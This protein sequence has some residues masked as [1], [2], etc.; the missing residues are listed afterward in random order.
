MGTPSGALAYQ[1]GRFG[2]DE[3]KSGY[4]ASK[5]GRR[6]Y[7]CDQTSP[8]ATYACQTSFVATTPSLIIYKATS[9]KRH[10]VTRI[11]ASQATTAAGGNITAHVLI[12]A[13]NR[14]SAGGTAIVPKSGNTAVTTAITDLVV[15]ANATASAAGSTHK[16]IASYEAIAMLG[17]SILFDFE[18][19]ILLDKAACSLLIYLFAS[20]TAPTIR[21]NGEIIEED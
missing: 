16:W 4:A 2:L 14:Y 18:D 11:E 15:R 21:W 12:D 13:S 20:T 7:I 6:F 5:G 3:R 10:V 9:A 19:G 1:Q 17:T 8:P